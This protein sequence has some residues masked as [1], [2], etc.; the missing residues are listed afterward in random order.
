M[1]PDWAKQ[2]GIHY[3]SVDNISYVGLDPRPRGTLIIIR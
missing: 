2:I 3:D 1:D